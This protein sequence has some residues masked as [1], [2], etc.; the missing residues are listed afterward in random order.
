MRTLDSI[1]GTHA[2]CND[3][4]GLN[5]AGGNQVKEIGTWTLIVP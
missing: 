3:S 2:K 5:F 4:R 1:A